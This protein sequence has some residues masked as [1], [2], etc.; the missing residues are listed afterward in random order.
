MNDV[1]NKIFTH[2][3]GIYRDNGGLP[4]NEQQIEIYVDFFSKM[5]GL[6]YNLT[7]EER[8]DL[9]K[10][11]KYNVEVNVDKRP[12]VCLVEKNHKPWYLSAKAQNEQNIYWKRYMEYL[13]FQKH[14][15]Q[16]VV[17]SIDSSTDDI[18]DLLGNP[19][20]S[21]GIGFTRR[22]LVLGDVQSGKTGT[23]IALINKAADAGYKVIILLTGVIEKLRQQTQSRIDEGFIGSDS[24]AMV[25]NIQTSEPIG[26]GRFVTNAQTPTTCLT[27]T[28]EDF[29]SR[30][31]NN[32][33]SNLQAINGPMILVVKKNK[34]V[35][36]KLHQWFTK[37]NNVVAGG[38]IDFP[39]LL[40]DD[41]ADNA[42]I[43]TN[44]D[45]TNPTI[46]NK[47]IRDLLSL[48]TKSNY[49]GFTA[50][51]Y[52]NIFIKPDTD[53]EMI[54]ADLFPR[55]FIY[56]LKKPSNYIGPEEIF[57]EQG[58]C[59]FMLK[60]IDDN[61][62][63]VFLPEKH[64]NGASV[65]PLP[66]PLKEAICSFFIANAILD[67]RHRENTHRSM[68]INI[69]RFINVQNNIRDSVESFVKKYQR[70]IENYS[71]ASNP[72]LHE[73]LAF[74]KKV[75]DKHFDPFKNFNTGEEKTFSW[76]EI[77][78]SLYR[79]T[80]PIVVRS[81]NKDNAQKNLSYSE[82]EE[83]GLRVI[84][85][86][87]FSLSRGLTLEGLC[88]SYYY[89]NSKMYDTLM[90]MGRWFGY[91]DHYS[92][93]CQIWMNNTSRDWYREIT[94]ATRELKDDL[95]RMS[96]QGKTPKEFGLWVRSDSTALYV[97][98]KN[99][100]R[101]AEKVSRKIT[102]SGKIIE[103]PYLKK[104]E[105]F[106]DKIR[107][108]TLDFIGEVLDWN[109]GFSSTDGFHRPSVPLIRNVP[110]EMITA[111]LDDIK[112]SGDQTVIDKDLIINYINSSAALK[113]W[114]VA[115]ATGEG[116]S[117]WEFEGRK[118]HN[119]QRNF[120]ISDYSYVISGKNSR[121]GDTEMYGIGLTKAQYEKIESNV[122]ASQNKNLS[123]SDLFAPGIVRNPLLIIYPVE[124]KIGEKVKKDEPNKI[125]ALERVLSIAGTKPY[126]AIGMGFPCAVGEKPIEYVYTM[127]STKRRELI[128]ADEDFSTEDNE[129][130]I[131][132]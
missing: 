98:A 124:L 48:F 3:F 10:E 100:M 51:P 18:M 44:K 16:S 32:V 79:A 29:N 46:I 76:D 65:G 41:E 67:L 101:N 6:N 20:L 104:S 97:T 92:D 87:G 12:H 52:A 68:L 75:F 1:Q 71:L 35:L 42:S 116:A 40:I 84:A 89:R 45:D 90:Q 118:I 91:R 38:K 27:S 95:V 63:N 110:S 119:V 11:I 26:V 125:P 109:N 69:S 33:V 129:E 106:N 47:C 96:N 14:Y 93:V 57:D 13:F 49:V 56:V 120:R 70:A 60:M 94:L 58:K 72:L 15:S 126:V 64:K 80:T 28:E 39:L 88:V 2:V 8:A 53:D 115:I 25:K 19:A 54:N 78:H 37:R 7:A 66:T 128:E 123:Q 17:D 132:E 36:T 81:V 23:Y 107:E 61:E 34:S 86:G 127:N 77:L 85:V 74:I 82:Y 55:D 114:D 99:K 112:L 83:T 4:L 24:A 9:I 73:E 59:S 5:P 105:Q 43:N 130:E 21:K 113:T 30:L 117:V 121:V 103:T 50:T 62:E 131:D 108:R 102:F 22:G 111:Y 31:A 122:K